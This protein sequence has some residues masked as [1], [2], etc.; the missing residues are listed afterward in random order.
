[1]LKL[2]KKM[3]IYRNIKI[4]GHSLNLN[5]TIYLSYQLNILCHFICKYLRFTYSIVASKK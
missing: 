5:F 2:V 4:K 3:I 1:M